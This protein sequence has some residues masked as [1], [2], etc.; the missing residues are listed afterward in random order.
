MRILYLI[1]RQFHILA[2][3]KA[4]S[5]QGFGNKDIASKAGCP[6][7]AVRKYGAQCK[8]Y[9][10][11]QIRQAVKDGTELEEA[12][13]TGQLNDQLAV[14]LFIIQYSSKKNANERGTL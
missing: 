2:I 14:E 7:W 4:M 12:V 8:G 9:S 10:L 3:V 6:E 13:K 1:T 11:D 5:N